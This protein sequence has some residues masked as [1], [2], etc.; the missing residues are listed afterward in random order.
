MQKREKLLVLKERYLALVDYDVFQASLLARLVV[1]QEAVGAGEWVERTHDELL[2]E[3]PF[4]SKRTMQRK[5]RALE[6]VGLVERDKGKAARFRVDLA[7]LQERVNNLGMDLLEGMLLDVERLLPFTEQQFTAIPKKI[8]TS[9]LAKTKASEAD[10]DKM[11]KSSQQGDDKMAQPGV[12]DDKM[13]QSSDNLSG[14]YDKMAK[15]SPRARK[16]NTRVYNKANT[17]ALPEDDS[18]NTPED[19]SKTQPPTSFQDSSVPVYAENQKSDV[20][21]SEPPNPE[22][23]AKNKTAKAKKKSRKVYTWEHYAKYTAEE[24]KAAR[25]TGD[26]PGKEKFHT[27]LIGAFLLGNYKKHRIEE[28]LLATDFNGKYGKLAS[29]MLQY[30]TLMHDGDELAGFN[31]ALDFIKEFLELPLDSFVGKAQWPMELAFQR[32]QYRRMHAAKPQTGRKINDTGTIILTQEQRDE[33]QRKTRRLKN[34][35]VQQD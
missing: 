14:D 17:K 28:G 20:V 7:A 2:E 11:A 21:A 6:D 27:L 1:F 26:L 9:E 13:A 30:F 31:A 34:G 12:D 10:Y 33:A 32:Q 18:K 8:H 23:G 29:E 19:D 35:R 4:G 24:W 25:E 15:S 16:D 3:T 5:L 22:A